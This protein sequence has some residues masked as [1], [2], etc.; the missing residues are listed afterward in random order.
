[1]GAHLAGAR[2]TGLI[3]VHVLDVPD[4]PTWIPSAAVAQSL[5]EDLDEKALERLER[6]V[7]ETL[8]EDVPNLEIAFRVE[9]GLPE[10]RL[11]EIAESD[12]FEMIVVGETGRHRTAELLLGST[13]E[14]V[15]RRSDRPV[16][17]VP[18]DQEDEPFESIVV[19]VDFS[20]SSRRA[21]EIAIGLGRAD[22]ADLEI[23][24][25]CLPPGASVAVLEPLTS[26][27]RNEE[28]EA[29]RREQ[30]DEF[31]QE[32]DFSG[33]A[34]R[35]WFRHGRP[36]TIVPEIV[37]ECGADLIV[38]GT[39]GRRGFEK[40][41]LGSTAARMLRRMPSAVLTVRTRDDARDD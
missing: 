29:Q 14:G 28:F 22:G 20:E 15:V 13:A 11:S 5:P 3:V 40:L 35:T 34:H 6:F 30:F 16:L 27:V 12:D 31:L 7:D 2:R 37:E 39:Q 38:M 32:F 24:H 9:R 19:P 1:M 10:Q 8:S 26:P 21:L 25:A 33:L 36:E 4:E 41:L 18:E 17:V 23:V